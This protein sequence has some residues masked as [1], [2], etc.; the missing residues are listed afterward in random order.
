VGGEDFV[1]GGAVVVVVTGSLARAAVV[2]DGGGC[3]WDGIVG[4]FVEEVGDGVEEVAFLGGDG[5]D[6]GGAADVLG[7]GLAGG[8]DAAGGGWDD[9]EAAFPAGLDEDF[10]GLVLAGTAGELGVAAGW[11]VDAVPDVEAAGG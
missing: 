3:R 4:H 2:A 10:D 1:P 8:V 6:R 7:P 9:G 11:A 5:G